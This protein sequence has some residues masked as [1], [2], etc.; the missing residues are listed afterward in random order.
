MHQLSSKHSLCCSPGLPH[1]HLTFRPLTEECGLGWWGETGQRAE[2]EREFGEKTLRDRQKKGILV[3]M[4][5][6]DEET[7]NG[8]QGGGGSRGLIW[9]C[10]VGNSPFE[11]FGMSVVHPTRHMAMFL[12]HLTE[13]QGSVACL[14]P[15]HKSTTRGSTVEKHNRQCVIAVKHHGLA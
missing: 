2:S 6:L 14:P 4:R 1:T 8:K 15:K 10:E 3:R 9:G 13:K 11:M 5:E 12:D 7:E